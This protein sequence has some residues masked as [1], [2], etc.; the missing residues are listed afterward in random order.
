MAHIVYAVRTADLPFR[1]ASA[2]PS[3]GEFGV[4]EAE[5]IQEALDLAL[6][7]DSYVVPRAVR[8]AAVEA[9]L[10]DAQQV[11]ETSQPTRTGH[12]RREDAYEERE[13]KR[14]QRL[15]RGDV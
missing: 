15:S 13:Q 11:V 6:S 12:W 9:L 10:R 4:S 8:L 7:D 1:L 5:I 2:W 14:C 3:A